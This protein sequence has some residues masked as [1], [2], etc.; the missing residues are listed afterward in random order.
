MD[1]V[2]LT[3]NRESVA[4]AVTAY[5]EK[6]S[7]GKVTKVTPKR[8]GAVEVTLETTKNGLDVAAD[9]MRR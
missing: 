9:L 4:K 7:G 5:A 6:E 1:I 8:G 3:L 2:K